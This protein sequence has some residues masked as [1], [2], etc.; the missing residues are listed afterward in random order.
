MIKKLTTIMVVSFLLVNALFLTA[1][2]FISYKTFLDISSKD[3]SET[4]LALLNESTNNLS[5]YITSVSEAGKY[6]AA[7]QSVIETFSNQPKSVYGAITEQRELAKLL[8]GVASLKR[9]IDS[10]ELFTNRYIDYPKIDGNVIYT[11][12][13]INKEPWFDIFASMDSAWI[14]NHVSPVNNQEMI[15]YIHLIPDQKGQ[16]V[17]F[18]KVNV[19]TENF[20]ANTSEY[21]LTG[22]VSESVMVLNTGG[23]VI[24]KLGSPQS[25][26][27]LNNVITSIDGEP[28][29]RLMDKYIKLSNQYQTISY[30]NE[31]YL[32]LVSETNYN[33]WRLAQLI[34][35]EEL[36]ADTRKTSYYILFLGIGALLLS[37]PL[38]YWVGR[39]IMHPL[40]R[41]I[42]G[43]KKVEQGK[44]DVNVGSFYIEE[45]DIL[46]K[47]FNQMTYQLEELFKK[48][49]LESKYRK[50]AEL[51]ALQSEIMP[52]FLYNTLDMIHWKAMDHNAKEISFMANQLSK[53]FRIGLSGGKK[54]I[55]LR[56]ELEH[57]NSYNQ[58]QRAR[59]SKSINYDLK[60]PASIKD[61]YVPKIILQ[62]F[63]ENSM[64]HGYP[65]PE[66][67][68]VIIKVLA[69]CMVENGNEVLLITIIDHGI[70]LPNNWDIKNLS[71]VGITN[72]RE[73]IWL[74]CGKAYG[75]RM[76][77][78]Q[79]GGTAV[80]IKLP[81]I[82]NR[83]ELE[84]WLV[85]QRDWVDGIGKDRF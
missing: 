12:D 3:I 71:G 50:E 33:Q 36:F 69:K 1:I 29:E 17:A 72:V 49:E 44:F 82:K 16:T 58:I 22:N 81:A 41:I 25:I 68:T 6:V 14:P 27:A 46:A 9:D 26:Q 83:E 75:I 7:N 70:G 35:M 59:I 37:I 2:T 8:T 5:N 39:R 30:N 77:N 60:V 32:F 51:K 13:M 84:A 61:F 64:I 38:A 67:E 66:K 56:D 20:F 76:E 57:A 79:E 55:P 28:S 78:R 18:L 63:I 31:D 73:R 40:Q 53:M 4:R 43:M 23:K 52:H 54:F 24:A 34:P 19:L 65:N 10:I 47:N 45:Y 74:Y 42:H 85:N 11:M 15:S 80:Q 62:P 48:W 21:N